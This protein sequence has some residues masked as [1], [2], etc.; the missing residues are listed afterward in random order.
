MDVTEET[1]MLHLRLPSGAVVLMYAKPNHT[2]AT[3]TVLNFPVASVERVV[4]E[5]TDLGVQFE[6]Y[7]GEIQTDRIT[8]ARAR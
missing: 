5:L 4:D 1:G 6:Q 8:A 2:P 7:T 3:Y